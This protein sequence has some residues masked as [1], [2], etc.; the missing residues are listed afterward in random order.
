MDQLEGKI[1][2][3]TGWDKIVFSKSRIV[4]YV[5]NL[6]LICY[7]VLSVVCTFQ[8]RIFAVVAVVVQLCRENFC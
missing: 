4:Q 1:I 5:L 3:G 6:L 7:S 2:E 8:E